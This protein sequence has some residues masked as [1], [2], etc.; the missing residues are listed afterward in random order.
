[1]TVTA[2]PDSALRQRADGATIT[3]FFVVALMIIPARMVLRG[4][5]L[6]LT[7][8]DVIALTLGLCW[9]LAHF[10]AGLSM[11]KGRSPVRTSV[12]V[13]LTAMLATYG[14]ATWGYLPADELNLTDHALVLILAH[15]GLALLICDGVRGVDRLNLL[16]KVLV[17]MGAVVSVVGA[18]QFIL[19]WDPTRLLELPILRYTSEDS[20]VLERSEFRRVAA[21]MGHPIE[22]GVVCAMLLPL[23]A[24]FGFR[25]RENG[26]PQWRW[27]TCAALI[28]AGL[29]FSV[30]RSAMLGIIGVGAILFFGWSAKQRKTVILV[31]LGFLVAMRLLVP[32]LVSAIWGLFANFGSDD[33]IRYRLHDYAI[34]GHEITKHFW[35]GRGVSTWYAPKHQVFDNQYILSTL[36]AG[37]IGVA[38]IVAMFVVAMYSGLRARFLSADPATR[39]LGLTLTACLV[40]PLIGAATFDLLSFATVTGLSFLLIGAAGSL[41]RSVRAATN[42]R[43]GSPADPPSV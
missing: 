38:S 30:S 10:S 5:P 7:L 19:A 41:L 14:Y 23:A 16:L 40:V 24:H 13:Y 21:T 1:M 27:W 6:S 22:F 26:E 12:F 33:S 25:A 8:A 43:A 3:A 9:L 39:D 11:A 29:M 37:V 36:E 31:S 34:A 2:L 35:L 20:F 17:V 32:G 42:L 4:L 15:V 18:C 28:G